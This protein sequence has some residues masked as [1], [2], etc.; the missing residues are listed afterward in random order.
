MPA[1]AA[2]SC[3][4]ASRIVHFAKPAF[5]TMRI[6]SYDIP[7][8]VRRELQ[9]A[10]D[11]Q[12]AARL[13]CRVYL[14]TERAVNQ[15][16]GYHGAGGVHRES[17]FALAVDFAPVLRKMSRFFATRTG[18]QPSHQ[19]AGPV[20]LKPATALRTPRLLATSYLDRRVT[21]RV[22]AVCSD[23]PLVGDATPPIRL[24]FPLAKRSNNIEFI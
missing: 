19:T 5:G 11:T 16:A 23:T 7:D 13:I 18:N 20:D 15:K 4:S 8:P 12:H 2:E 6:T 24:E 14:L 21:A 22:G 9:P 3:A 1:I 10:L 17:P